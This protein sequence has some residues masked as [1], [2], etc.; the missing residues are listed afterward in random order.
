ML[1]WC[2]GAVVFALAGKRPLVLIVSRVAMGRRTSK[3]TALPWL[4][5]SNYAAI[6]TSGGAIKSLKHAWPR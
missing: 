6:V 2:E 4:R 3:P 1:D 5:V